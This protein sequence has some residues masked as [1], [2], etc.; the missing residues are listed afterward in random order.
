M[1]KRSRDMVNEV[2]TKMR[3]GEGQAIIHHIYKKDELKGNSRLCAT[4]TLAPGDAIGEHAHHEEEEIYYMLRGEAT[5]IDDGVPVIIKAGDSVL[6]RDGAS[7]SIINTG[8]DICEFMA[9][10]NLYESS[11]PH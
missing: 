7:H 10:I 5:V 2:K 6:T 8:T 11:T 4:I 3:G 1:I 9:I